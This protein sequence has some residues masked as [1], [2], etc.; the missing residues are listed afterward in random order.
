MFHVKQ[1]QLAFKASWSYYYYALYDTVTL[2]KAIGDAR[3][4]GF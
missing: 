2:K 3:H 1:F 4:D